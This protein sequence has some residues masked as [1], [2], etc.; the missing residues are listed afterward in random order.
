MPIWFQCFFPNLKG[1]LFDVMVTYKKSAFISYYS[2]L[3]MG[4]GR[5]IQWS[6]PLNVSK[7]I[8]IMWYREKYTLWKSILRSWN[9]HCVKHVKSSCIIYDFYLIKKI[10]FYDIITTVAVRNISAQT[11]VNI[12][13]INFAMNIFSN[14][15]PFTN[16]F[17]QSKTSMILRCIWFYRY[18]THNR[19][20]T[21]Y[22]ETS[23]AI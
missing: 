18:W 4:N 7:S 20:L 13:N 22:F 9:N 15:I 23:K 21:W 12:F 19:L 11:L 17:V 10:T 2:L 6:M 14:N 3:T 1:P 8:L 5:G 16:P